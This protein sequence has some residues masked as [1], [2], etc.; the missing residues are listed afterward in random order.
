MAKYIYDEDGNRYRV[1]KDNDDSG[2]GGFFLI[3][4]VLLLVIAFA[5]G[6][7]VSSLFASY[8]DTSLWAWIWSVLFSA[9]IFFLVYWAYNA[10]LQSGN[11]WKWTIWTYVVIS[12][13]SIWLLFA[14][15]VDNIV[16]ICKLLKLENI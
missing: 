7:V 9:G 2:E 5:P 13:L 3:L 10:N 4:I 12:G 8:I 15:Q 6:M 11:P 14:S 1:E 16:R